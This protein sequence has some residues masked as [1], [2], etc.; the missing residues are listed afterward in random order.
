MRNEIFIK[1]H[2]SNSVPSLNGKNAAPM[3]GRPVYE[4]A[5]IVD[6]IVDVLPPKQ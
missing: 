4:R 1:L 2:T 6:V 3:T 5:T